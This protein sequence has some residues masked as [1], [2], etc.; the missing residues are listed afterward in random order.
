[1]SNSDVTQTLADKIAAKS[2]EVATGM[3]SATLPDA[4]TVPEPSVKEAPGVYSDFAGVVMVGRT[5][6]RYPW[7][8]GAPFDMGQVADK[9]KEEVQTYLDGMIERGFATLVE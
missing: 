7:P 3:D 2:E 8:M 1:M 4:D 6:T 5:A 9:H